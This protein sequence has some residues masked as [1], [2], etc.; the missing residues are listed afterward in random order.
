MQ[1]TRIGRYTL[2][3]LAWFFTFL[4]Q[5]I[6]LGLWNKL[7]LTL[8]G[9]GWS[10]LLIPFGFS[11]LSVS[12]SLFGI[13]WIAFAALWFVLAYFLNKRHGHWKYFLFWLGV[14]TTVI[15]GQYLLYFWTTIPWRF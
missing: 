13:V 1:L 4:L 6:W 10:A 5:G 15:A 2:P 14:F 7:I 3:V 11:L 9:L 8:H 12:W